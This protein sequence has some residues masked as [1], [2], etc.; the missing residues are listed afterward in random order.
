MDNIKE[1]NF[2]IFDVDSLETRGLHDI[3]DDTHDSI[4]NIQLQKD[5]K[6]KYQQLLSLKDELISQLTQGNKKKAK[7]KEYTEEKAEELYWVW[8]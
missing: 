3:Y 6:K 7:E 4:G 8:F 2:V 5:F 1:E